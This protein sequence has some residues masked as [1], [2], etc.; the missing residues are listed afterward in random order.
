MAVL[1]TGGAG[2]IGSNIVGRLLDEGQDVRVLDDLSTGKAENLREHREKVRL[3]RG[4]INDKK[5]LENA[6]EDVEYVLHQAAIPSVARSVRDPIRS[7]EANLTGT[8]NVLVGARDSGVRRVVYAS[9]SSVYGDTPTLPKSEDM[10]PNPIS[11][12]AVSKLGGEHYCRV[13]S[14]IY[15]L[16]TVS[17]RY[18]NVFGPKQDPTS[19]YAAVIPKFITT[20]LNGDGPRVYGDGEQTRDFTYVG[21]V[22]NANLLSMKAKKT[23]GEAVNIG[24]GEK[25][26]VNSL[27][28]RINHII[29]SDVKAAH[30]K[31]REGD[32]R[33]SLADI[34]RAEKLIGYTPEIAFD[35][36]LK[37]TV[38]WFRK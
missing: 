34:R 2:F 17:L 13:F 21:N 20:I 3:I 24:C 32:I 19:E 27:I 35:E 12:Y 25:Y 14:R 22:V 5:T 16:E 11:P 36:G 31:P 37:R 7:N 38:E 33:D 29:G 23:S 6:L 9:S 4:S 26:S 10:A 28:D 1:V 15:G 18:F 8:L 30:M